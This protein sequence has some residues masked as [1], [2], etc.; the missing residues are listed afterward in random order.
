MNAVVAVLS[1][2][3]V[4][5]LAAAGVHLVFGEWAWLPACVVAFFLLMAGM[6]KLNAT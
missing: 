5:V 1:C 3:I 6:A 4:L 2:I